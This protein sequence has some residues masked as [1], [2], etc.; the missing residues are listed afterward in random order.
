MNSDDNKSGLSVNQVLALLQGLDPDQFRGDSNIL[1]DEF[2]C[3]V[4]ADF[5]VLSFVLNHARE[6]AL[7]R[8][9]MRNS[10]S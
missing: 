4:K 9:S 8:A 1:L 2:N 10:N 7:A 5:V 3:L 6:A